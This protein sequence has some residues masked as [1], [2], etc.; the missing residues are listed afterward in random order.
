MSLSPNSPDLLDPALL[1]PGR[2]DKLIYLGVCEDRGAQ[3]KILRA[4]TRKF[5][6]GADVDLEAIAD[7]TP[8]AFTGAD[9]YALCSSALAAAIHRRVVELE[10]E[11]ELRVR[12]EDDG[13]SGA[14]LTPAALLAEKVAERGE[15]ALAVVVGAEDFAAARK[16]VTPSVSP[17]EMVYYEKIRKRFSPDAK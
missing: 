6:L 10:R 4:L 5:A 9:F 7:A 8:I 11:L 3:L 12:E 15:A 16:S 17:D 13:Y 1:R 14:A 2:F